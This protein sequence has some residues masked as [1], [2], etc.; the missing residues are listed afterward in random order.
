MPY[1]KKYTKKGRSN[2]RS[3]YISCGQM[4]VS[5]A[6]KALK[7]ALNVRRLINVEYKFIDTITTSLG[8]STTPSIIQLSNISQGD[9]TITRDGSQLKVLS[10]QWSYFVAQNANAVQSTLR[11]MLIKDKQTNQAIFAA[12]DVLSNI[13]TQNALNSPYNRDNRKRFTI[14][15][16][17]VHSFSDNGQKSFHYGQKFSQEQILR[18]DGNAGDITDLTQTSYALLLVSTEATN[19]P[20]FTSFIRLNFVDN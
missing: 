11:C 19:T 12:G 14:L 7:I 15:Y 8:V 5:D 10:I 9:T 4:V 13:T 16:D 18:Y 3:N 6:S 20:G 1:K 2:H 17:K